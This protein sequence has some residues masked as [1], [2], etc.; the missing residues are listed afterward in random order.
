MSNHKPSSRRNFLQR[1]AIV[2]GGAVVATYAG[3]S[4]LRRYIAQTAET[5]D[6]PS[7][8]SSY[9]PDFW[10]QML[11]DNTILLKS[12]K[13]EM[14]QGIF[15][16]FA[17]MAAEELDVPIEQIKVEHASTASGIIDKLATGG[18]NSTLSLF[19][20]IREVAAT[21]RE[22][23]KEA[24]AT[25]WGIKAAD[26][27]TQ[28]GIMTA[29]SKTMT[30][31]QAAA[32]T[33]EWKVPKTP[34]LKPASAFKYIGKA[35]KRV[36]LQPKVMGTA[37]YTIDSKLPD[38]LYGLILKSPYINGTLKTLDT[39]EAEKTNGFVQIVR[40]NNKAIKGDI[41]AVIAKN[42]YAAETALGK[43]QATWDTPEQVQQS[44]LEKLVTVGN[45]KPVS[46]Q[47]QGSAKS[48]LESN[49]AQVFKQAYRTPLGTHAAMEVNGAIAHVTK[50]KATIIT[51]TQAPG[52]TR[53]FLS[54]ALSMD[55]DK[56][57]IQIPYLGGGFGRKG[58][59]SGAI[60]T[61]LVAQAVGKPVKILFTRQQEFQNS[62]YRPNTHHVLQ[63]TIDANGKITAMTHDQ[64]T[65]DMIF[66]GMDP[67]GMGMK[68]FG[69]DFI[70]AGHGARILYSVKDKATTI[71][72]TDVPIPIGI[73]RS[74]GIFANTF[75]IENF[76]D[77][78]AHK[79]NKDPLAFRMNHLTESDALTQRMKKVLQ[80]L[81]QKSNWNAPKTEGVGRGIAITNDRNTIAAAA[82]E[83]TLDEAGKIKVKKVVEVMDVGQILNPEGIRAQMEGCIMMG[84]S[85]ALYEDVQVKDNQIA[86]TNFHEFPMAKLKDVPE[87][88][89]HLLANAEEPYGVGEP[90]IGPI[91]PAIAAAIFDLTGKRLRTLP[92]Q[93]ALEGAVN[94]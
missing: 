18:S 82:I 34:T 37:K 3:C 36:D 59:M 25:Q 55:K 81:A 52:M 13:I 65:P 10:F 39:K 29:G 27:S 33:K 53:D 26:I 48:M 20:S 24:A 21:M 49:S 38:M 57:D 93:K 76:M 70:S 47:R 73:W 77:E 64:A 42:Q 19:K 32:T 94:S 79:A 41:V 40:L 12:P 30:Y 62:F 60:E 15:T 80:A 45:G 61:A 11:A 23:L 90:P 67:T 54:S 78:L 75:A 2:L 63:A 43:I 44:D 88:E 68:V 69:A 56:I 85:A 74:V 7:I 83:V 8:I 86:I 66:K 87:I 35:V 46:V 22:M 58:L 50:D 89:T 14:G 28:N 72:N 1:G 4:P 51:G 91:A 16:G 6:F 31:A 84:I 5:I 17:M 92:L 71:W 9:Q